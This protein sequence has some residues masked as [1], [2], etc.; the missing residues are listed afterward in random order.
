MRTE[1]ETSSD[2][3]NLHAQYKKVSI[4]FVSLKFFLP[5]LYQLLSHMNAAGKA[6]GRKVTRLVFRRLML[7]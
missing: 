3:D 4:V 1:S 2:L 7:L 6:T 5:N